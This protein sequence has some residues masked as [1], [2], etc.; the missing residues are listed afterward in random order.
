MPDAG[1]A[2]SPACAVPAAC[3]IVLVEIAFSARSPG[4]LEVVVREASRPREHLGARQGHLA[5]HPPLSK[6]RKNQRMIPNLRT[7]M[8][9][10]N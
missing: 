1:A 5:A 6:E 8:Y 3:A 10:V 7:K 2:R 4:L 9:N